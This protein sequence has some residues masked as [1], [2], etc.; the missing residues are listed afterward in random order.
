MPMYTLGLFRLKEFV[1]QI[2][3]IYKY[4]IF[5]CL[6][7]Y[8]KTNRVLTFNNGLRVRFERV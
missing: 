4:T 6:A 7:H 8:A 5:Y 3:Y 1:S 2:T